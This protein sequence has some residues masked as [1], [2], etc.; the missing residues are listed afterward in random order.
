MA[1]PSYVTDLIDDVL[2]SQYNDLVDFAR[3]NMLD[4][5]IVVSIGASNELIVA[6][7][8]AD[9]TDPSADDPLIFK[10][11]NSWRTITSALSVTCAA[12][13]NTLDLGGVEMGTLPHDLFVYLSWINASSAIAIGFSRIGYVKVFSGSASTGFSTSA[14][15]RKSAIFSS[16]PANTDDV[17]NIGRFE[18][19]LSLVGTGHLWTS[20]SASAPTGINTIQFPITET[21][22][23]TYVSVD[24][25]FTSSPAAYAREVS[26][27][28]VGRNMKVIHYPT[29]TGGSSTTGFTLTL[30]FA[31]F[32]AQALSIPYATDNSAA[33]PATM[34]LA[35]SSNVATLCKGASITA[36][37]W[38]GANNKNAYFT[39]EIEIG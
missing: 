31:A 3:R 2:A 29:A 22:W 23:L 8:H 27:Q 39:V 5:K 13:V 32:R 37:S 20:A 15:A 24:T 38:T 11:G 21:R 14:T 10:I 35:A 34:I 1:N 4:Y 30:P 33:T 36:A 28:V 18:A 19:T 6:L 7:K 16:T 25:G 17:V 9:G 12:G 26:Y